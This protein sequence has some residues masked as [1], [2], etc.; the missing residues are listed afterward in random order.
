MSIHTITL[1]WLDNG[2]WQKRGE[3]GRNRSQALSTVRSIYGRIYELK[4]A[5]QWESESFRNELR[6]NGFVAVA[7][8]A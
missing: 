2:A 5:K 3:W 1:R 6:K 7:Y 4:D 8:P